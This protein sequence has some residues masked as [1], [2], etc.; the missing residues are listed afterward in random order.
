[1]TP[2]G[3]DERRGDAEDKADNLFYACLLGIVTGAMVLAVL[4][5]L[6]W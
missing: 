6:L 2:Y 1:M 4:R 5:D 3:G